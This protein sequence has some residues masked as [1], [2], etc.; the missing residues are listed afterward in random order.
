MDP[1]PPPDRAVTRSEREASQRGDGT[2]DDGERTDGWTNVTT[3]LGTSRDKTE[4][5]FY[6]P[7]RF[8]SDQQIVDLYNYDGLSARIVD[9]YPREEMRLGF[10]IKGI[11]PSN[12]TELDRYLL[13]FN[14]VEHVVNGRRWGRALGGA[15]SWVLVDDGLD[16]SEPLDE[17]RI[18]SV[19]G[20][21]V[22]DK[23]W[24]IPQTYYVDGPN[25][26]DPEIYRIQEPHPGGVG[27]TIGY[28][29]ESRLIRWPG[30]PCDTLEQIRRRGW[31]MSVL[32]RPYESLRAA[33]ETWK[34]IELIVTDANQGIYKVKSL[35][36][37]I[38]GDITQGEMTEGNPSGGGAFL[39]R[40][41]ILDKVKSVFRAIVLDLDDEDYTRQAQT[42]TGLPDLSDRAWL[43]VSADSKIPVMI[44]T[45]QSPAGL[46][47]TGNT[48]IQWY[49]NEAEAN[50][51][52]IDEPRILRILR[53]LLS[54][55]DAPEI[56][57]DDA[58]TEA[59]GAEDV[60]PIDKLG[61]VWLPL[62]APTAV[63]LATIR[64]NRAQEAT[65][66]VTAQVFLPEEIALSLP[67]DW[68]TFDRDMRK[69]SLE[70][71]AEALLN[72]KNEAKLAQGA[73]AIAGAKATA[74]DPTGAKAAAQQ[75]PGKPGATPNKPGRV[76]PATKK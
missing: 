35:Y 17:D 31:E 22:I 1:G 43:R 33:G 48:T 5:G 57:F 76:P 53:I 26:G 20:L 44:L 41:Q 14:L 71:D 38:A 32:V 72:Q 69:Q 67:E 36:T 61:I 65:A 24:C 56:D 7:G 75:P 21:R 73:A 55:Q 9:A 51:K 46:S 11:T 27:P 60:K 2:Y 23:R 64:L 19:L 25:V 40:V 66:Y 45:G 6:R 3:G 62:W 15:V 18:R 49:Y 47:S 68:Y 16:V 13:K 4:G 8:L 37:K 58:D 34:A 54:A 59:M 12:K 28:V 63:E 39:K 10:G 52:I 74:D 42:F 29:H 50:R 30:E 70:A